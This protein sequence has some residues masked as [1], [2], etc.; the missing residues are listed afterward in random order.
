[1]KRLL[2]D[3]GNSEIKIAQSIGDGISKVRRYKYL[4]N[5]FENDFR[6]IA[7][8]YKFGYDYAGISCLNA[9]YHKIITNILK[10]N[11]NITPYFVKFESKLPIK[12][13][14]EKT[15]GVDRICSAVAATEKYKIKKHILI[16]DFGTATTYNLVSNRIY[17]GGM[18]APGISTALQS[19]NT[20][21][22]LPTGK[23]E[24]VKN[25]LSQKTKE[26]I[27]SGVIHQSIFTTEAV[28]KLL[29]KKYKNLFVVSTGGFAEFIT[30]KIS[31]INILERNLV[32]EGINSILIHNN[33]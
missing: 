19:L 4:K 10:K 7:V 27:L 15:L 8:N 2:I 12:I 32:L 26:N 33:K 29:K 13:K 17:S 14:Y 23:I 18:I 28:I 25:L 1:M 5:K 11:L 20:N 22:N 9:S 6:K 24:N 30:K 16:I 21:A 3:I 31:L